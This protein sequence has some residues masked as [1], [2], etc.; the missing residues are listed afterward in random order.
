MDLDEL[1]TIEPAAFKQ[2][3]EE[4]YFDNNGIYIIRVYNALMRSAQDQPVQVAC[5]AEVAVEV[6]SEAG[7]DDETILYLEL[8]I[9]AL[10]C[11]QNLN[12]VMLLVERIACIDHGA[13]ETTVLELAEDILSSNHMGLAL[14]SVHAS[15]LML[16][17]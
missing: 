8:Q 7:K 1:I 12:Q 16:R 5:L 4:D 6:Y 2:L 10:L 3:L 15:S 13:S 11:D 9:R 17:G 14:T